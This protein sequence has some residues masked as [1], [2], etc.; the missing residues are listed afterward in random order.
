MKH[1]EHSA[2]MKITVTGDDR[3][4]PFGHFL[5]RF[6]LDE[7]PQLL[8]VFVGEMSLVGPRPEVPEYIEK[9]SDV[10][11]AKVL[12]VRPGITDQ[13]SLE[14]R[15]E[16]ALL[17]ATE[18]PIATYVN[19]VLP[20]KIQLYMDYVDQQSLLLDFKIIVRTIIAVLRQ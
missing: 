9:Y 20:R 19:D 11:R 18:D 10:E 17:A 13:A 5:R 12:S 1:D 7:L 2:G 8:N 4:T 16:S 6:K 14:F 3:I 15:N